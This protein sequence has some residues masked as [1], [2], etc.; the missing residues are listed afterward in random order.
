MVNVHSVKDAICS[1]VDVVQA[2]AS[3]M[4]L[5]L[6]KVGKISSLAAELGSANVKEEGMLDVC[7]DLLNT[8]SPLQGFSLRLS[9]YLAGKVSSSDEVEIAISNHNRWTCVRTD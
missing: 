6:P 8:I 4:C 9:L 7:R 3:S 5:L 2:M 1:A